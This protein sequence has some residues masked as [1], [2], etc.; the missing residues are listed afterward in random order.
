MPTRFAETV[1]HFF[2]KAF[3]NPESLM[4]NRKTHKLKRK[5]KYI[6]ADFWLSIET[7]LSLD[8]YKQKRNFQ[9]TSE[10]KG[11]MEMANGKIY[12]IQKHDATRLHFD[13][14]LE[15]DEVLKSWAVPKE[16]PTTPGVK[17]LAVQVED[18]PVSYASFEGTIPKGEYGAGTVEI[19]DKGSF[20]LVDRKENKIIVEINGAKLKGVYVLIRLKSSKNWLFFKKK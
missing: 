15:M 6:T 19:W 2:N 17:R 14:R 8:K 18:H 1:S 7:T 11:E 5:E 16:P 20:S 4:L 13:L 10:P 9:K 3:T 12:V